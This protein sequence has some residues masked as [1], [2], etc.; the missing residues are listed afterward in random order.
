MLKISVSH[1]SPHVH[2]LLLR[3]AYCVVSYL[4]VCRSFIQMRCLSSFQARP[5]SVRMVAIFFSSVRRTF[6]ERFQSAISRFDFRIVFLFAGA[7][8]A[9]VLPTQPPVPC[10]VVLTNYWLC[11][12]LCVAIITLAHPQ[13]VRRMKVRSVHT[14]VSVVNT[15]FRYPISCHHRLFVAK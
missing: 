15:G 7:C 13:S 11:C 2:G 6:A 10:C 14:C 9:S 1:V 5:F 12:E 8:R 3:S 4:F